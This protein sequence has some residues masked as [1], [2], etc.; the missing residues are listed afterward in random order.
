MKILEQPNVNRVN[1]IISG[2]SGS[3][4][5]RLSCA[6]PWGTER[7]GDR[8]GLIAWDKGSDAALSV[9]P[10]DREH[11]SIIVPEATK[12]PDGSMRFNPYQEGVKIAR[13]DWPKLI[14]GIKTLI[15]DGFT[16]FSEQCLRAFANAGV[17]SDKDKV[18]HI[19][20]RNSPEYMQQ[21]QMGDYGMAQNA[22][23]QVV[24]FL[25]QQP[26]NIILVCVEDWYKP[27][28]QSFDAMIGGPATVGGKSISKLTKEF[29][30]VF[31]VV[32]ES[33]STPQKDGSTKTGVTRTV[34]TEKRSIWLAK[35]RHDQ[36]YNPMPEFALPP[37]P[38]T[39][40]QTFDKY[41]GGK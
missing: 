13:A 35:F 25:L 1:A 14:P 21:P 22:M 27:E 12:M 32:Q 16:G 28:G 33:R 8:A 20:E 41:T 18:L 5:S 37:D 34:Y 6:L 24:E 31:R 7:W 23:M 9:L 3:G 26:L 29:D 4:K 17:F 39:F 38:L 15:W 11:L 36:D 30:N 40:W 2:Q 19:G 10:R